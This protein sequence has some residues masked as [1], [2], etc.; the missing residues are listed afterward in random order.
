MPRPR[1]AGAPGGGAAAYRGVGGGHDRLAG[2]AAALVGGV[3]LVGVV[4]VVGD[5]LGPLGERLAG[6]QRLDGALVQRRPL[7]PGQ[8]VVGDLADQLVAE[9]VVAGLGARAL[10]DQRPPPQGPERDRSGRRRAG[11]RAGPGRRCARGPPRTGASASPRPGSWSIRAAIAACTVSGSVPAAA[12]APP[13]PIRRETSSV[14]KGLPP[15]AFG[16]PGGVGPTVVR[17]EQLGEARRGVVIERQELELGVVARRATELG[18]A[19]GEL[20]PAGAEHQDRR[21]VEPVG[22]V[23]EQLQGSLVRPVRVVDADRQ[24]PV[25]REQ[26]DEPAPGA[27]ELLLGVAVGTAPDGDGQAGCQ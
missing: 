18:A 17:Q 20:R 19:L 22:D 6:T 2:G 1:R 10:L 24:R 23:L 7:P 11:R 27:A 26:G 8:R 3:E 16:D 5:Q 12:S 14:K 25:V 15:A 13:S 21:V 4:E 9:D